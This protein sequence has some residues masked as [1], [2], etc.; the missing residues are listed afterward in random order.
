MT[1]F[2]AKLIGTGLGTGYIPF[3][4]GTFGS[5]LAVL[6][7]WLVPYFKDPLTFGILV[8]VG[9][10]LGIWAGGE[11]EHIY[12]HDPSEVTIDEVIGQWIALFLLPKTMM[13]VFIAFLSFRVFDILKIE[14]VNKLQKL[15]KGFGVMMD[16]V[17]AG[18][19]ANLT[20]HLIIW[21]MAWL[22]QPII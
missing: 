6:V 18:I 5:L 22:G 20:C 8:L 1:T 13:V 11:L 7:Y 10:I 16:D 21:L 12:G 17:M 15:P 2:I 19:Y 9:M 4:S 14:P 3:A